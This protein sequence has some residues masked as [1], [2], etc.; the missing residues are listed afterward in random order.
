MS[1][2]DI[3]DVYHVRLGTG[4][5]RSAEALAA[6]LVR[7]VDGVETVAINKEGG[8]VALSSVDRDLYEDIVRAAVTAGFAPESVVASTFERLAERVPLSLAEV[9]ALEVPEP[10]KVPVRVPIE[11]HLMQRVRIE[12]TD[13]YD[14]ADIMVAAGVPLEITFTEGNGCLATV[15]FESLGIEADLTNGGAVVQIPALEPGVYPFSC[16]MHMVHG[17]V[18]AE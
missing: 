16:G 12:V 8:L 13:G 6:M 5:C 3:K 1:A 11:T 7:D 10:P 2:N 9:V 14:P 15:V 18:T 17:S 4:A